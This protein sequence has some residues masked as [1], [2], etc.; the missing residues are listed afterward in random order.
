MSG[1]DEP[2]NPPAAHE[3]DLRIALLARELSRLRSWLVVV[4]AASIAAV[5]ALWMYFDRRQL[6]THVDTIYAHRFVLE[7]EGKARAELSMHRAGFAQLILGTDRRDQPGV[8]IADRGELVV[9]GDSGRTFRALGTSLSVTG[10]RDEMRGLLEL[11]PGG[12]VA[13]IS[14]DDAGRRVLTIRE[15]GKPLRRTVMD[16]DGNR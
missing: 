13:W 1:G 7:H 15:P 6:E 3:A 2:S 4:A 8:A 11:G 5:A 14:Y 9:R 10:E 16:S 12:R